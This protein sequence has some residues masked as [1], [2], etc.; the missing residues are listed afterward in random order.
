MEQ[1]SLRTYV[2]EQCVF[3]SKVMFLKAASRLEASPEFPP[4]ATSPPCLSSGR[5]L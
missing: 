1:L 3:L 5:L 4:E 2:R